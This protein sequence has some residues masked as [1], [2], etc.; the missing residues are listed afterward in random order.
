MNL[1]DRYVN[2]V[3][4]RLPRKQ[5]SDV[6]DELRSLLQDTMEDRFGDQPTEDDVVALL[7]D[8]GSPEKMAASY[9]PSGQYLVGPELYP[10][11]KIVLGAV[12]LAVTIGLTAAFFMGAVVTTPEISDIGQRLLGYLDGYLKAL[13]G[14]FALIVIVFAILQR[15]GVQ[16]DLDEKDEWNPRDLPDVK[17]V[18][19]VGRA[20]SIAGIAA[21][22]VFL[23][24]LNVFS[25]RIGIVVSWRDEPILNN[26][27]QDNLVWLNL[28]IILGLLLNIVLLWK[29]RW[30]L[31]TRMAKLAI[32]LLWVYIIYQIVNA[33]E[34][35]KQTMIDAGLTE[36][37]PGMIVTIGYVILA[38]VAIMIVVNFVKVVVNMARQPDAGLQIKLNT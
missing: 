13:T 31:Y 9:R 20:E 3:G 11:F 2:E 12:L 22:A 21:A 14:S 37:L 25:D 7:E 6:Q 35:G 18:D 30:H 19:V 8:F 5:R 4:R 26:I 28:A 24:L 23:V 34:A 27:A 15:L 38:V 32:D 1:I 33:L 16:P 29:G 36:P 17:D 10:L